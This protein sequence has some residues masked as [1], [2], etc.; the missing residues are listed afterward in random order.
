MEEFKIC[1]RTLYNWQKENKIPFGTLG[2]KIYYDRREIEAW[3]KTR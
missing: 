2:R 1:P 3:L